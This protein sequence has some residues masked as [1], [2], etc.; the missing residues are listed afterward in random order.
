MRYRRS[1]R[2]GD[3][4]LK[5]RKKI[6]LRETFLWFALIGIPLFAAMVFLLNYIQENREFRIIANLEKTQQEMLNLSKYQVEHLFKGVYDDLNVIRRSNEFDG[7]L[8]SG[9]DESRAEAGRMFMRY[10]RSK[11]QYLRVSYIDR[12]GRKII[13]ARQPGAY[14]SGS[15]DELPKGGTQDEWYL[16]L[17]ETEKNTLYVSDFLLAADKEGIAKPYRPLVRFAIPILDGN[18]KI[19]FL[20]IDYDGFSFLQT[21]NPNEGD[22]A[23]GIHQ[24]V[25][26]KEHIIDMNS[27]DGESSLFSSF[28]EESEAAREL[29]R[30][31]G[32]EDRLFF[33]YLGLHYYA[34]QISSDKAFNLQF[35]SGHA[36]WILVNSYNRREVMEEWG[37]LFIRKP[38][39]KIL[40]ILIF[41]L[42]V[43]TVIFIIQQRRTDSLQMEASRYIA[44]FSHDGIII[45]DSYQ[46]FIYC[47]G[48]F[49]RAFGFN[50]EEILGKKPREFLGGQT[51]ISLRE[52]DRNDLI[53]EGNIW[54]RTRDNIFIQKYL[55]VKVVKTSLGK[56]A[57]YIGVYSE[58][59]F[60]YSMETHTGLALSHYFSEKSMEN[61]YPDLGLSLEERNL[62]T[63]ILIKIT[64]LAYLQNQL[65][66]EETDFLFH[67]IVR[68][69]RRKDRGLGTVAIPASGLILVSG[70]NES[71]EDLAL[72]M[73]D[74]DRAV[75][76]RKMHGH[77]FPLQFRAGVG[78]GEPEADGYG[79][80]V[81]HAFIAL[82][83]LGSMR[84]TN[85][86]VYSRNIYE[87][88]M[89]KREIK[90]QLENAFAHDEFSIVYQVQ[91]DCRSRKIIGVE[92]LL[93]WNSGALGAVSPALF[94][95]I[96]EETSQIK[97][98][99][100]H[101]VGK[102][103]NE[104][105]SISA[106]I[107]DK[108]RMSINL[109]IQEFN[110]VS[111]VEELIS[112]IS[113]SSVPRD[114]ICFEITET[115]L[116]EN[117]GHTGTIIE[118]FHRNGMKVAIDDFG[119]GYSSLSYLKNLKADKIKIDRAFIKDYPDKDNGSILKAI[120][121]LALDLDINLILEGVETEEQLA[122]AR[123]I[124]CQEF[125]GYLSSRPM[126]MKA[127][128][129]T[130]KSRRR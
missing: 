103:L 85:Y 37:V 9:D 78:L 64:D 96:M 55:K 38:Y 20:L 98:L 106:L 30:L 19:G 2:E 34:R 73:E 77:S 111:L 70:R 88:V 17:P 99:G 45:T 89:R 23:S 7:Y 41:E 100:K 49:E 31:I 91:E 1:T 14:E 27:F 82:E 107:D 52:S 50:M 114:K 48:G 90:D 53:W 81:R 67:D 110:D 11:P 13:G 33:D 128:A 8:S 58:P 76:S 3:I 40:Y 93:R 80:L 86:L 117:L 25:I 102:I 79:K 105:D 18:E 129:E 69:I 101:V 65:S 126:T 44:E 108:F 97:R 118:L 28:S 60:I 39:V 57:F 54:D 47:N 122:F 125:Q 94:V 26:D 72:F 109:S 10:L 6:H 42:L 74:L 127:L 113:R 83:A 68:E 22:R 62:N 84:D 51:A 59:K 75:S 46:C 95:P 71:R 119:T 32:K 35:D 29:W 15:L 121:N 4:L 120:T 130:L 61:L 92:A 124:G 24:A 56:P 63:V 16:D 104:F 36:H 21:L 112:M 12:K 43:F 116:S 115:L 87:A 66:D 5:H 123:D